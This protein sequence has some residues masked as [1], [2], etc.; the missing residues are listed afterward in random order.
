MQGAAFKLRHLSAQR[1]KQNKKTFQTK[2]VGFQSGRVVML[3]F[4][5]RVESRSNEG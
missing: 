4:D 5:L 2:V 3:L 1:I